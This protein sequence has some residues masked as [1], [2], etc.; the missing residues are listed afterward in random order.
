MT[1]FAAPRSSSTCPVAASSTVADT[2]PPSRPSVSGPVST[3]ATPAA[4]CG[5]PAAGAAS[6]GVGATSGLGV[7]L[8]VAT[9]GAARSAEPPRPARKTPPTTATTPMASALPPAIATRAPVHR[10]VRA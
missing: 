1:R 4:V 9:G 6:T 2:R 3:R 5:T 10:T 8:A 7:G